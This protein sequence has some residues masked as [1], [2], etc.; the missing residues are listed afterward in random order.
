MWRRGCQKSID[1]TQANANAG[2]LG[3]GG[4]YCCS[5]K[6]KCNEASRSSHFH[7]VIL[8][9]YAVMIFSINLV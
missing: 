8:L 1:C 9:I 4:N 6:D 3:A 2:P 5:D 7:M